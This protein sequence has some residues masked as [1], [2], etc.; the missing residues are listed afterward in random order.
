MPALLASSRIDFSSH[1]LFVQTSQRPEVQQ[2][3]VVWVVAASRHASAM[4]ATEQELQQAELV[5]AD[6]VGRVPIAAD[7]GWALAVVPLAALGWVDCPPP[8]AGDPSCTS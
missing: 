8:V 5:V 6:D 2:P 1:R 7:A 3:I 4:L